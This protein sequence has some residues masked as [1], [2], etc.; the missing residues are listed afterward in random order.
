MGSIHDTRN[1]L[2][3]VRP[4]VVPILDPDF[5]PALLANRAFREAARRRPVRVRIA[6]ERTDGVSAF[7]T[8]MA[9]ASLPEAAGNFTYIERLV[10]FLLWSR[11]G[12]KVWFSGPADL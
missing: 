5:R 9:D 11:G 12:W 2:Q 1:G 6:V 8:L 7:D 10:K 4:R 3:L